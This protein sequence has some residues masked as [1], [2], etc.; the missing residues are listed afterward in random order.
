MPI[1]LDTAWERPRESAEDPV[2]TRPEAKITQILF[3]QDS[4]HI[5]L[6]FGETVDSNW[7]ALAS[8]DQ[9][10]EVV[11][12]QE[13]TDIMAELT[14]DAENIHDA[15]KRIAYDYLQSKYPSFAGTVE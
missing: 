8:V 9:H 11:S 7:E 14:L 13:Y 3:L 6:E 12:G 2:V 10:T 1:T 5:K 15:A 4:L